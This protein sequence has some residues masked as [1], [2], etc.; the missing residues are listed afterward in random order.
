M[1]KR[2]QPKPGPSKEAVRAARKVLSAYRKTRVKL[3]RRV[4]VVRMRPPPLAD[5][6][7]R[8]FE[9][10][11]HIVLDSAV[12]AG[13]RPV[14]EIVRDAEAAADRMAKITADRMP[15]GY[16]DRAYHVARRAKQSS[17]REWQ[18][19]FDRMIHSMS[20]NTNLPARLVVL[21]A[22]AIADLALGVLDARKPRKGGRAPRTRAA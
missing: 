19:L 6:K 8:M 14:D 11:F 5:R 12:R 10:D 17:W 20:Q 3:Y 7:Y 21:R 4:D 15:K 16:E 13:N 9:H 22:E 2:K 1:G 18:R